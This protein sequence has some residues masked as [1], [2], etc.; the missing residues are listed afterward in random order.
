MGPVARGKGRGIWPL[1]APQKL[2]G[3]RAKSCKKA[4]ISERNGGTD[5]YPALLQGHQNR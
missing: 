5:P 2:L 4:D 3:Y 1:E